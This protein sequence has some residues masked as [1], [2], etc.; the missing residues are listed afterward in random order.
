MLFLKRTFILDLKLPSSTL[1]DGIKRRKRYG[2]APKPELSS[3]SS[4][5]V[6]ITLPEK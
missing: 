6:D 1:Y 5:S 4:S 3:A 2:G